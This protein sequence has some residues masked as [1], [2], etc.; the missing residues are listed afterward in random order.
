MFE[1]AG[2]RRCCNSNLGTMERQKVRCYGV[3]AVVSYGKWSVWFKNE[4]CTGQ[5]HCDTR[6]YTCLYPLTVLATWLVDMNKWICVLHAQTRKPHCQGFWL[7]MPVNCTS[8]KILCLVLAN[9]SSMI[10][11]VFTTMINR[12]VGG[13]VLQVL[14]ISPSN[15]DKMKRLSIITRTEMGYND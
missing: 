11:L 9:R 8:P 14:A 7:S 4:V 12:V 2:W 6:P 13:H 1:V 5:E 3:R 15:I 10:L